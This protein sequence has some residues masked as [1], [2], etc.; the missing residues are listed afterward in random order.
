MNETTYEYRGKNYTETGELR[1]PQLGEFYLYMNTDFATECFAT[2]AGDQDRRILRE[3]NGEQKP[4]VLPPDFIHVDIEVNEFYW[5]CLRCERGHHEIE[6]PKDG[7][8]E[9]SRCSETF[10]VG[11]IA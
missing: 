6:L 1:P 7:L 11:E 10:R 3:I 5:T 9:C 8:L 4:K 2:Y